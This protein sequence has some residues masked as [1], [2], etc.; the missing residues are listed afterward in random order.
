MKGSGS[1]R[2]EALPGIS[3]SYF[4]QSLVP[5]GLRP[6]GSS[7]SPAQVE[8]RLHLMTQLREVA[9]RGYFSLTTRG[10]CALPIP[11][12]K[13]TWTVPRKGHV[14]Q[15][16]PQSVAPELK[17]GDVKVGGKGVPK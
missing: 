13:S 17:F 4:A 10:D 1:S 11:T 14:V 5:C 6:T 3:G 7:S 2:G 9:I 15:L 12:I 8:G 16:L